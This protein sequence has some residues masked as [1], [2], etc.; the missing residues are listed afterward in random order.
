[1]VQLKGFEKLTTIDEAHRIFFEKLHLKNPKKVMIPTYKALARV[2]AEDVTAG[3]DLP[4]SNR[5]AMDGYAVKAKDTLNASQFQPRILQLTEKETVQETEAQPVWTG[6][7][8]PRGADAVVMLEYT[9]KVGDKIEVWKPVTPLTNVTKSGED[10]QKGKIAVEGGTWLCFH[11][12]GLLAA[13]EMTTVKVVESPKIAVLSTGDELVDIGCQS[14]ENKVIDVNRIIISSMCRQLGAKPID[15]GIVGDNLEEIA[16]RIRQGLRRADAVITTGGTSVGKAD[17]VPTA[18]NQI[19]SPGVLVHGIAMRP[20]M[21]TALAILHD[22][23]VLVLSGNPVAAMIG[24]DVFARP[25]IF[26]MLGTKYRPRPTLKAKLTRKVASVLGQR[27]FLRVYVSEKKGE[28]FA[29]PVRVKGSG[30][31]S[32][33]TK[34]NGYAMIPENREGLKKEE[35]VT[36][37]LFSA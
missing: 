17:L 29:E 30:I 35:W 10:V 13:L 1:L 21:P 18:I 14:K 34:A 20:G 27:V 7:R 8:L 31:L 28:F 25:A 3:R 9:K 15:L 22:K 32:T 19:G 26:K 24:F 16:I 11:H 12:L 4:H 5:S 33:M 36:V 23:P 2:L 6:T 37:H